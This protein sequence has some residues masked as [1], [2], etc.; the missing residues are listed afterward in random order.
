M[1][2]M[3]T[4]TMRTN[5]MFFVLAFDVNNNDN[6]GGDFDQYCSPGFPADPLLG[7]WDWLWLWDPA[8]D[9]AI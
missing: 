7:R 9:K 6:D 8:D 4:K 5:R 3:V 1:M 2:M